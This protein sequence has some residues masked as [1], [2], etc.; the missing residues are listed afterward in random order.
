MV[1]RLGPQSAMAALQAWRSHTAVCLRVVRQGPGRAPG[2]TADW[3][4][5]ALVVSPYAPAHSKAALLQ[6]MWLAGLLDVASAS[7]AEIPSL[8]SGRVACLYACHAKSSFVVRHGRRYRRSATCLLLAW[9]AWC[10]TRGGKALVAL[11]NSFRRWW[12]VMFGELR[13]FPIPRQVWIH[14]NK[15]RIV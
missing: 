6:C 2:A 14:C 1:A 12:C 10:P 3:G 13:A 8:S 9:P 15:G 5:V 4:I 11:G 7:E